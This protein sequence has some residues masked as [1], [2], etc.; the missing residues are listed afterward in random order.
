M[1]VV[2]IR[3]SIEVS[4]M[5]AFVERLEDLPR[6]VSDDER[7]AQAFDH[8]QPQGAENRKS[9]AVR[10]RFIDERAGLVG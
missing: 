2:S 6:R 10:K 3:E 7:A 9:N 8:Q 1:F 5:D 4:G